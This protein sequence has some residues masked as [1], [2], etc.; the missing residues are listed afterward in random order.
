MDVR[1]KERKKET[2]QFHLLSARIHPRSGCRGK[3]LERNVVRSNIYQLKGTMRID[4]DN[5][6]LFLSFN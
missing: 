5:V 6:L 2:C 1:P 4:L 3:A